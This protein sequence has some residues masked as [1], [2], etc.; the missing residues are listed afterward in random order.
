MRTI[1]KGKP[2]ASLLSGG[3][4]GTTFIY[5]EDGHFAAGAH[6]RLA[7]DPGHPG[8]NIPFQ[9][10]GYANS[11]DVFQGVEG[12]HNVL[13][14]G[15][16]HEAIFLSDSG[17][18]AAIPGPRLINI[19]EIR[20]GAGG[21]IVDLTTE[22]YSYGNVKIIGGSGNDILG[23]NAGNDTIYGGKGY[24]FS[25]GGSG[26][27]TLNGGAGKD[28]VLGGDG[29]DRV[30]GGDGNDT[31][32][33]SAGNDTVIGGLG[34]DKVYGSGG[35]DVL[36]GYAASDLLYG[37][38][39]N[40]TLRGGP[41]QDQLFGGDGNDRLFA[42]ASSAT[43]A[44]VLF[45]GR[46][47]DVLSAVPSQGVDHFGL[48][49]EPGV[50]DTILGFSP[51][52]GDKLTFNLSDF[53]LSL[54]KATNTVPGNGVDFGGGIGSA[55]YN[56]FYNNGGTHDLVSVQIAPDAVMT[57]DGQVSGTTATSTHAQFIY[58]EATSVGTL[59]FDADGSK[60]G[61]AVEIAK[62]TWVEGLTVHTLTSNDFIL[63][64]G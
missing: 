43:G 35:D 15:N 49:L 50:V 1:V 5:N 60:P 40:D 8:L 19:D 47:A 62:I 29:N 4:D 54:A 9:T 42:G 21:Q 10:G 22:T 41:G 59:Y 18:Q 52:D 24:D 31:V 6:G 51:I 11:Q 32:D 3:P 14:M 12:V 23:G 53:G 39:G 38:T 20:A 46:G 2:G 26:D 30:V 57:T 25:W 64:N 13:L 63:V 45:G 44:D 16:G 28:V 61:A 58:S 36:S 55:T 33:G 34:D 7:G 27:D 17:T 48:M 56:N 37:G